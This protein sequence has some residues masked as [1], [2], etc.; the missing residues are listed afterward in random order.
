MNNETNVTPASHR[1]LP[2]GATIL[3]IDYSARIVL[4]EVKETIAGTEYA[5]WAYN[6]EQGLASTSNGHYIYN[7]K[8]ARAD[9]T[10]RVQRGY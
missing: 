6:D 2:N 7:L 8:Q 10:A 1:I 3:A 9:F 4:A 5:T